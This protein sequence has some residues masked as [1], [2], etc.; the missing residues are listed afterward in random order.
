MISENGT[1]FKDASNYCPNS[2]SG[3]IEV[4]SSVNQSLVGCT[5]LEKENNKSMQSKI[6]FY[7][8]L[9]EKE[10]KRHASNPP[11]LSTDQKQ[12]FFWGFN[13]C[14]LIKNSKKVIRKAQRLQVLNGL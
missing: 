9:T 8:A 5:L 1:P 14:G 10:K 11:S 7:Q 3:V 2:A 6:S 13:K 4:E 12:T